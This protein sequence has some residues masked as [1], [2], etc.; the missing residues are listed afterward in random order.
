MKNC[1][2][3]G[4]KFNNVLEALDHQTNFKHTYKQMDP[5]KK[6]AIV[7]RVEGELFPFLVGHG[8]LAS[9]PKVKEIVIERFTEKFIAPHDA[10]VGVPEPNWA[11]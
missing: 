1:E 4:V 2:R 10:L 8:V 3:C 7:A 5:L 6:A 11:G 9:T